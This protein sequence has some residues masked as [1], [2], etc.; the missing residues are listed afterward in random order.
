VITP[1]NVV[2][3]QEQDCPTIIGLGCCICTQ[4]RQ[5][6]GQ[7]IVSAMNVS[8]GINPIRY[9]GQRDHWLG[10]TLPASPIKHVQPQHKQAPPMSLSAF[11][12]LSPGI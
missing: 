7:Q 8:D 9:I 2:A 11:V 12:P 3:K 1:I 5:E 6:T 4:S 10:S